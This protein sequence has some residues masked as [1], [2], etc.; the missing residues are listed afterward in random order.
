MSE[1]RKFIHISKIIQPLKYDKWY[2]FAVA[3][4]EWL[5][6]TGEGD[7]FNRHH[8]KSSLMKSQINAFII[9]FAKLVSIDVG[10]FYFVFKTR[11]YLFVCRC[12]SNGYIFVF[13]D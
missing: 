5:F 12:Y 8:N 1:I 10:I 4:G 6:L 2:T 7:I 11:Y 3:L 13:D 9:L